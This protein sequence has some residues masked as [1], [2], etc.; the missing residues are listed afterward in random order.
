MP[1]PFE[2]LHVCGVLESFIT[3]GFA[4]RKYVCVF[5]T[6]THHEQALTHQL[7]HQHS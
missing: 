1:A 7:H 2:N 4:Y 3:L 5:F 6:I